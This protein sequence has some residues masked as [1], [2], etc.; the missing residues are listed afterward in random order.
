M[1]TIKSYLKRK[2]LKKEI[3]LRQRVNRRLKREQM[4]IYA[5]EV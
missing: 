5:E 1:K 2:R 4:F 3:Q